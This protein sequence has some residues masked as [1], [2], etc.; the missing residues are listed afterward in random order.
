MSV[1][2]TPRSSSNVGRGETREQAMRCP[3]AEGESVG[4]RRCHPGHEK[5]GQCLLDPLPPGGK[6]LGEILEAQVD[7]WY[8]MVLPIRLPLLRRGEG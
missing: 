5:L 6:E 8:E 4:L 2:L 7:V 1:A 3:M